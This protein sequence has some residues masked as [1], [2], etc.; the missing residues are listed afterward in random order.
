MECG[1]S[2]PST[3][4]T[5]PRLESPEPPV[6]TSNENDDPA[7]L[8]EDIASLQEAYAQEQQRS[9][10][11][12]PTDTED[13]LTSLQE[14]YDQQQQQRS[15]QESPTDT[16]DSPVYVEENNDNDDDFDILNIDPKSFFVDYSDCEAP[17]PLRYDYSH[18]RI[19]QRM[20]SYLA[21]I[22]RTWEIACKKVAPELDHF[23]DIVVQFHKG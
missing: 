16:E 5:N 1:R 10:Q 22:R 2:E 13:S 9:R 4:A 20:M 8:I 17:S 14:T 12:S 11:V 21:H 18:C 3:M 7:Q 19:R 23:A 6:E 15:R